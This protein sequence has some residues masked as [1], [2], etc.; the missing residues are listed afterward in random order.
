VVLEAEESRGRAMTTTEITGR[1]HRDTR[2]SRPEQK[3]KEA[4]ERI[5]TQVHGKIR[6]THDQYGALGRRSE[7]RQRD[8]R[9]SKAADGAERKERP[10]HVTQTRRTQEPGEADETPEGEQRQASV[11]WG[12]KY[13]HHGLCYADMRWIIIFYPCR[14][15]LISLECD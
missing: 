10:T 15:P 11:E 14:M 12:V 2:G 4:R 9:E 13:R 6:Q 1:E 8:D 3:E 5:T 7:A